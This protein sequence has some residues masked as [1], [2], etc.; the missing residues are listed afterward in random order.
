MCSGGAGVD[1][2][3]DGTDGDFLAFG[4]EDLQTAGRGRFEFVGNLVGFEGD[5]DFA[6]HDLLA[7]FF[8]PFCDVCGSDGLTGGGNLEFDDRAGC[9]LGLRRGPA[10]RC[11][12]SS[13]GGES[14]EMRAMTVPME[15]SSPSPTRISSVPSVGG[16]EFV[17]DLVGFEGDED[18]ALCDGVAVFLVPAGDIG[19]G[20]GFAGG[21]NFDVE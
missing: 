9:G 5:Q 7:V 11:R 20:D 15:T 1:G 10:Q 18:F 21:G 17:G 16:F 8:T 3:D 19:G 6:L 13:C 4:G 2:G 12:G 14:P